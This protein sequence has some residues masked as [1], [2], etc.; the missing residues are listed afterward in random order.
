MKVFPATTATG[1][2]LS[3]EVHSW[4]LSRRRA[5]TIASRIPGAQIIRHPKRFLSWFREDVFCEF[6]IN[7]ITFEIEEP[8]GDNSRF[9]IGKQGGGW[10]AELELVKKAFE[11]AW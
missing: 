5:T 1:R 10:C 7:A 8:L 3:F 9:W 2:L 6:R 4:K 11:E